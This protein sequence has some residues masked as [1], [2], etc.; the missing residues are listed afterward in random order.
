M[1]PLEG[2]S[3]VEALL[4]KVVAWAQLRQRGSGVAGP[5]GAEGIAEAV[6][7]SVAVPQGV[8]PAG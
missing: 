7:S 3:E 5:E 4:D 8:N 1:G 6:A 2:D